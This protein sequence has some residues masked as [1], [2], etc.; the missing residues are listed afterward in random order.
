MPKYCSSQSKS[1]RA[2]QR[3]TGTNNR[4]QSAGEGEKEIGDSE[5]SKGPALEGEPPR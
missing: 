5:K 4:G 3:I 1:E 2:P